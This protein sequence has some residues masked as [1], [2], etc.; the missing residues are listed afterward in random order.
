VKC[1]NQLR[2]FQ[3]FHAV[4]LWA[5]EDGIALDGDQDSCTALDVHRDW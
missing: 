4:V 5:I 2:V 3:D 1:H